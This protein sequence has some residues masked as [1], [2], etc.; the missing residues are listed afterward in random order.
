MAKKKTITEQPVH[1]EAPKHD[2]A[3]IPEKK[4]DELTITILNEKIDLLKNEVSE[5]KLY[6]ELCFVALLVL[7]FGYFRSDA[8]HAAI[9][10]GS[11]FGKVMIVITIIL[12][13]GV[14]YFFY[15]I[16]RFNHK[17]RQL[18]K[19]KIEKIVQK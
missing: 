6:L 12:Y 19:E 9:T 10:Q 1:S 8:G 7:V 2:P 5:N 3:K 18:I 4:A 17:N 16:I 15:S 13:T 11:T 14:V